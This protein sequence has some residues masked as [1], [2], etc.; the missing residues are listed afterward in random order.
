M[1]HT[2]SEIKSDPETNTI[3]EPTLRPVYISAYDLSRGLLQSL[4]LNNKTDIKYIWHTCVE[5]EK[6]E[7]FLLGGIEERELI[8]T[9]REVSVRDFL[10][11]DN[12]GYTQEEAKKTPGITVAKE[13]GVNSPSIVESPVE[14]LK[15]ESERTLMPR[16]ILKK[17]LYASTIYG[18]PL[19]HT[20]VGYTYLSPNELNT[21]IKDVLSS[22]YNEQNYNL[23][24]NNCNNFTNEL[25]YLICYKTVGVPRFILELPKKFIETNLHK[26]VFVSSFLKLGEIDFEPTFEQHDNKNLRF[27]YVKENHV[28]VPGILE[29]NDGWVSVS[30]IINKEKTDQL[31]GVE[32]HTTGDK[33][34]NIR[35]QSPSPNTFSN[36]FI[37]PLKEQGVIEITREDIDKLNEALNEI[38]GD[39]INTEHKEGDSDKKKE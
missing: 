11:F 14:P 27:D 13:S 3:T 9:G 32:I 2:E 5:I 1:K 36:S 4:P 22:K 39:T 7:F 19:Y 31:T 17:P 26:N 6:R 29:D 34:N 10:Y 28:E 33:S 21:V 16:K 35:L 37:D 8:D 20:L 30:E 15:P 25:L 18:I 12:I 38:N 23:L 24:Y